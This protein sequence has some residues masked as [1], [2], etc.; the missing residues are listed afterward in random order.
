MIGILTFAKASSSGANI[1]YGGEDSLSP[2]PTNNRYSPYLNSGPKYCFRVFVHKTEHSLM[3]E[4][5]Q[6][7]HDVK[8][9]GMCTQCTL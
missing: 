7:W 5:G 3:P 4:I 6:N 2:K 1:V 9:G 8:I